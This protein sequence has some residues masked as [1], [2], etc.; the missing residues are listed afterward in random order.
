MTKQLSANQKNKL[1]KAIA[2]GK[3]ILGRLDQVNQTIDQI[4]KEGDGAEAH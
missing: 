2:L 4:K 1:R 3:Q